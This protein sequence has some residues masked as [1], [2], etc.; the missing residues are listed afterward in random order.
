MPASYVGDVV[1]IGG[2]IGIG[3]GVICYRDVSL[4]VSGGGIVGDSK[5]WDFCKKFWVILVNINTLGV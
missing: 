4:V 2:I 3:I 1:G 5:H